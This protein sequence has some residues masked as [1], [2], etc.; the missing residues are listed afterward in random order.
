MHGYQI[1]Q[2]LVER[3]EGRWNPS[4]GSIYPTLQQLQDEGLV[5][6]EEDEG[7]RVFHLTDAGRAVVGETMSDRGAP[8]EDVD[9]GPDGELVKLRDVA[10]Q[11]GAAVLQVA[12]A[13]TPAQVARAT[14]M[15]TELRRSLYR[16]LA[17][18]EPSPETAGAAEE[19]EPPSE[20]A[21]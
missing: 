13:G 6:S 15:L 19:P 7:R 9:G 16:L 8:W 14:Q 18:D 20:P 2:E 10:M 17:D 3:S 5:R 11:V 21:A 12:H 1:I 4:P